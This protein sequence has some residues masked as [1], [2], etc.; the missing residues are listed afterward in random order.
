MKSFSKMFEPIRIGSLE[1]KN[2]VMMAPC[3]TFFAK[4]GCVTDQMIEYYK[5]RAKGGVGLIVVEATYPCFSGRPRRLFV[6]DDR[7]IPGLTKLATAIHDAGAKVALQLNPSAGKSDEAA[8]VYVSLPK[9]PKS[10]ARELSQ[11]DIR[12]VIQEFGEGVRR[13][14]QSNF[15]GIQ[16]HGSSGYLVHQ[17]LS[18]LTN[19]RRDAYGGSMEKRARFGIELAMEAKRQAKG[20]AVL[21]RICADDHMA[22]GFRLPDAQ[23]FAAMLET[24]EVDS[25]DV[26]TGAMETSEYLRPG[27]QFSKGANVAHAR[28]IKQVIRIPVS[29]AGSINEPHLAEEILQ[30]GDADLVALGRPLIADPFYVNKIAE[31]RIPQI[32]SCILCN[33]GC[34]EY[35]MIKKTA[36]MCTVNP[37]VGREGAKL[38]KAP[39]PR[40]VLV[41]GGGPAGIVAAVTAA[42]KGHSV[43]LLEKK[44]SLGGNLSAASGVFFKNEI[45]K[46]RTSLIR[47]IE[48]A[49]VQL[50]MGQKADPDLIEKMH[51]DVLILATGSV[52]ATPSITGIDGKNVTH[53][54]DVLSRKV[55]TSG[56]VI[57]VGGGMM[58]CEAAV[59]LKGRGHEV[60]LVM[61]RG[62]DQLALGMES[63]LR[64]WFLLYLWPKIGIPL[65]TDSKVEAVTEEGVV[66]R[67]LKWGGRVRL[68]EAETVVFGYGLRAEKRLYARLKDRIVSEIY[69]IGDCER[70]RSILEA[71][72][73][74]YNVGSAL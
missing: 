51:P 1:L 5:E 52:P 18:P 39:K 14:R 48:Q 31:G 53:V 72:H 59:F 24:A 8:P 71:I 27:T 11:E 12:T 58:A 43:T 10:G 67:T 15:D 74:G 68:L 61:P 29:V 23:S 26:T 57:V 20:I 66:V 65:Y 25:I 13:A 56:R 49:P 54:A 63:R 33:Q 35:T 34:T 3:L 42:R 46:L 36:L 9:S 73:E 38:Q 4:D 21:F 7:F 40:D 47:E 60:T 17:F 30:N 64:R 50:L 28:A 37:L 41:V 69:R 45:D 16:I 70:P 62:I 19:H 22:G 6:F 44:M 32:S 2:R 55:D